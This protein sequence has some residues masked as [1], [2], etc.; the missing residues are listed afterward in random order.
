MRYRKNNRWKRRL[1]LT[2]HHLTPRSQNGGNEPA[3]ILMLNWPHHETWH[4]LFG[5]RTLEQ[6][7]ALL[8]R[9]KRIKKRGKKGEYAGG[10]TTF[11]IEGILQMLANCDVVLISPQ[12]ISAQARKHGF[13]MPTTLNKY[14]HDAYSTACTALLKAAE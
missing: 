2:R 13:A 1:A 14:Q 10:P 8:N 9:I 11:K 6:V 7:I 4:K 12:T 3:N 5:N